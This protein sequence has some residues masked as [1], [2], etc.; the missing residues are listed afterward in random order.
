MHILLMMNIFWKYDNIMD[1]IIQIEKSKSK[2]STVL[3]VE[4]HTL[5]IILFSSTLT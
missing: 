3:N 2:I 4:L 1:F 5:E